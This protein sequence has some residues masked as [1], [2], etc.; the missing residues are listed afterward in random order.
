MIL[1]EYADTKTLHDEIIKRI[2]RTGFMYFI[3][4]IDLQGFPQFSE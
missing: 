3:G 2:Q 1:V 4:S